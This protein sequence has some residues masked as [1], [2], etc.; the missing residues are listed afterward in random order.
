MSSVD[1]ERTSSSIPSTLPKKAQE[2]LYSLRE[3]VRLQ[4]NE[5]R[6]LEKINRN[7]KEVK[8]RLAEK[9][10][11]NA[12]KA[13]SASKRAA[14]YKDRQEALS[15]AGLP[16]N[17]A[18]SAELVIEYMKAKYDKEFPNDPERAKLMKDMFATELPMLG[19]FNKK[20]KKAGVKQREISK[21]VLFY[22][23]QLAQKLGKVAYQKE[24]ILRSALPHWDLIR[25]ETNKQ[26]AGTFACYMGAESSNH[27]TNCTS[28]T[29]LCFSDVF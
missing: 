18:R 17:K 20:G 25:K 2:E 3:R 15:N 8:D 29:F 16:L 14:K 23:T 10:K 27:F 24:C 6:E 13:Q 4:K 7:L 28:Q 22:G 5:I 1:A 26:T 9:S 12:A 19:V 21:E 11:C